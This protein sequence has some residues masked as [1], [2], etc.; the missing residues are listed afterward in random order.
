M[1][2]QVIETAPSRRKRHRP[3]EARLAPSVPDVVTF[4]PI[5]LGLPSKPHTDAA[6]SHSLISGSLSR[7]PKG[8]I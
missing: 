2:S 1:T 7:V 8:I 5:V 6:G 4:L 3:L